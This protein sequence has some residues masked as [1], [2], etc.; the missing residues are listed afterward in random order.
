MDKNCIPQY[1]RPYSKVYSQLESLNQ[2]KEVMWEKHH[3]LWE[4]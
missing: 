2:P 4:L 1:D 3:Q